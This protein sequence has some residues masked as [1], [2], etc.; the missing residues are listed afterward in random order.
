MLSQ[1]FT[2][3]NCNMTP[4]DSVG[5]LQR[6]PP[7][8]LW[9]QWQSQRCLQQSTKHPLW[10]KYRRHLVRDDQALGSYFDWHQ[11]PFSCYS[12]H[13]SS[14]RWYS[15]RWPMA[16]FHGSNS[17]FLSSSGFPDIYDSSRLKC[18]H[19]FCSFQISRSAPAASSPNQI[20]PK[21]IF[22]VA[23]S[24][25]R[26]LDQ[27]I[28]S[29]WLPDFW[30]AGVHLA[31]KRSIGRRWCYSAFVGFTCSRLQH[32]QGLLYAILWASSVTPNI[33]RLHQG[34]VS[35]QWCHLRRCEAHCY[36]P[37]CDIED[38]CCISSNNPLVLFH[39]P[40]ELQ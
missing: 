40:V 18:F 2:Q 8:H 20:W 1:Y 21:S 5:I 16:G 27:Q 10:W 33:F 25:T 4:E 32:G 30:S 34:K 23:L 14:G 36:W 22:W 6:H 17:G 13:G 38:L 9:L 35:S 39:V 29:R 37:G 7:D 11:T 12:V 15:L 31:V 19:G 24:F 26:A 3:M 28:I